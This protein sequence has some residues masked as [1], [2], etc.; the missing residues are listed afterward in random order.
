MLTQARTHAALPAADLA[1]AR[2]FY[3]E[4]LGL[5]PDEVAPGGVLYGTGEG[6]RFLVFPSSGSASG[7]H[8]QMGFTVADIEAEVADLKRRGVA[9]ESYAMPEFD[10]A[11][12]I[13]TFPGSRSAWFKDT[14]GNLL[15]VVQLETPA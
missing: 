10:I 11:T 8:T 15:G 2:R 6:T 1:R 3:E 7:T 4:V 14:E 12:S 9:F 5:V 13:A